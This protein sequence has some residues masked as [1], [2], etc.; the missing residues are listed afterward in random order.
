MPSSSVFET[1]SFVA[2][3]IAT[4]LV[5]VAVGIVV[6]EVAVVEIHNYQK[7]HGIRNY[8]IALRTMR[9]LLH[10]T[11]STS[12]PEFYH[13]ITLLIREKNSRTKSRFTHPYPSPH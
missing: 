4:V 3:L 13:I 6:E 5:V 9:P 2:Y 1:N 7:L 11:T 8:C 12:L 10:I